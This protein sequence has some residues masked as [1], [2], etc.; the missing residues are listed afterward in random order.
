MPSFAK[1][2]STFTLLSDTEKHEVTGCKANKKLPFLP[3]DAIFYDVV[4]KSLGQSKN[5][6]MDG[7]LT[8][9]SK[10]LGG[11]SRYSFFLRFSRMYF[12]ALFSCTFP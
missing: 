8:A 2:Y 1:F 6:N 12:H 9:S 4:K 7:F 5:P 11:A 3:N 10:E